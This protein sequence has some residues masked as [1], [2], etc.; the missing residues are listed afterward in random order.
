MQR[1]G[2][3]SHRGLSKPASFCLYDPIRIF[4]WKQWR[5]A[6]R[7]EPANKTQPSIRAQR[8]FSPKAFAR[9]ARC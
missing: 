3:I 2:S 8:L 6:Y 7:D 4:K 1:S 9:A 5:S